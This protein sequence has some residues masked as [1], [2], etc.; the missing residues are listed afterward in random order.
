[1]QSLPAVR[2]CC[3]G[4]AEDARPWL[5]TREGCGFSLQVSECSLPR[6]L[7]PDVRLR[8]LSREW[9]DGGDRKEE[10]MSQQPQRGSVPELSAV[11]GR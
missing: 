9:E 1:M 7:W 6:V 5:G 3:E 8:V 2:C 11:R 4:V 10:R